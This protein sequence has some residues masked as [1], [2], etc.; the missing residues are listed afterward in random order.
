MDP[1][2]TE[3]TLGSSTTAT[4]DEEIS[5]SEQPSNYYEHMK[6]YHKEIGQPTDSY[7][8]IERE[9][10]N[11]HAQEIF[12]EM[13][14]NELTDIEELISLAESNTEGLFINSI[15]FDGQKV[16]I[17][18]AFGYPLKFL[19]SLIS[20]PV[21]DAPFLWERNE[22]ELQIAQGQNRSGK[23][24]NS[25]IICTTYID[26]DLNSYMSRN[27]DSGITYVFSKVRPDSVIKVGT[28]DVWSHAND[29]EKHPQLLDNNQ[30]FL[31][32]KEL[33]EKSEID[34]L[35][36]VTLRRYDEKGDPL[37]PSALLLTSK[38]GSEELT[39]E[40]LNQAVFF[41]IPILHLNLES[42]IDRSG[43]IPNEFSLKGIDEDIARGE[44]I[45]DIVKE[46]DIDSVGKNIGFFLQRGCSKE[47]IKE[48]LQS[49]G[50]GEYW[51]NKLLLYGI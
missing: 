31:T 9:S 6:Q 12:E 28:D 8:G 15:P 19:K 23:E 34:G 43:D 30:E 32:P 26:T 27:K 1:R 45:N 5:Q 50:S 2:R 46:F 37:L 36:E 24:L 3:S 22:Q 41:N 21:I 47:I 16:K 38:H 25:S 11:K 42:Y 13:L 49:D 48:K 51:E 29:G 35:N 17:I 18:H 4:D 33:A 44:N 39:G 20:G 40:I 14:N 7:D 10:Q